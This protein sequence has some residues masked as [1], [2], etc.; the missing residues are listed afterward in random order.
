MTETHQHLRYVGHLV[1]K[2]SRVVINN[3]N[4]EL[5]MYRKSKLFIS[6]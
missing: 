6:V 1:G 4:F 3:D 5:I 2:K